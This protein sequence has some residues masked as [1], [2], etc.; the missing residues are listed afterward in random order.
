M[1]GKR[2]TKSENRQIAGVCAGI[3]ELLGWEPGSVRVLF[4]L[5][6]LLGTTSFW[7]YLALLLVS[8]LVGPP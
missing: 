2:L 7:A 1:S 3:A 4:L 5:G 6:I 8:R